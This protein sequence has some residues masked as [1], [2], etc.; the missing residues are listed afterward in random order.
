[1]TSADDAALLALLTGD[2]VLTLH[3]DESSHAA[4]DSDDVLEV[5]DDDNV[6]VGGGHPTTGSGAPAVTNNTAELRSVYLG[7]CGLLHLKPH[8]ALIQGDSALVL[9]WLDGSTRCAKPLRAARN[10]ALAVLTRL[11]TYNVQTT[12]SHI[13]RGHN[14]VADHLANRAMGIPSMGLQP[15]NGLFCSCPSPSRSCCPDGMSLLVGHDPRHDAGEPLVGPSGVALGH[16]SSA[17]PA[18]ARGSAAPRPPA[19]AAM[20][21]VPTSSVDDVDDEPEACLNGG[22]GGTT[23]SYATLRA[24]Y[25]R[26]SVAAAV[27]TL[28][29]PRVYRCMLRLPVRSSGLNSGP[30]N[31][32]A[33]V[34]PQADDDDDA[35]A[36]WLS[37][38]HC[39]AYADVGH[40]VCRIYLDVLHASLHWPRAASGSVL[41]F[42]VPH[43]WLAL[44]R[45]LASTTAPQTPAHTQFQLVAPLLQQPVVLV[46]VDHAVSSRLE[47]I[48]RQQLPLQRLARDICYCASRRG[49]CPFR[50]HYGIHPRAVTV[51]Y[52]ALACSAD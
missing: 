49:G 37:H 24:S 1:M 6:G 40:V 47:Q 2:D 50:P 16:F 3:S 12:M 7:L 10:A 52:A 28:P 20:P 26:A 18:R 17:T 51:C 19:S 45:G 4:N 21:P 36:I 33:E 23:T 44:L 48:A 5:V 46:G 38:R 35:S 8:R 15:G 30:L 42:L 11:R 41:R 43:D 31:V 34:V 13:G 27:A 14:A 25:L 32:V 9:K 29:A 39:P 22:D